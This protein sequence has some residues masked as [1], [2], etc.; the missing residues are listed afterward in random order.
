MRA[1][2]VVGLLDRSTRPAHV[3]FRLN[4]IL[5]ATPGRRL[6]ER[7][8]AFFPVRLEAGG[9]VVTEYALSLSTGGIGVTSEEPVD[10]NTDVRLCFSLEDGG[11]PLA[12][13]GR[14]VY[15]R[16]APDGAPLNEIGIVF[17]GLDQEQKSRIESEVDRLLDH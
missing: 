13:S 9:R 14:A 17:V 11:E 7:A 8:P 10:L 16:S 12:V 3:M 1:L 6:Y 5:H 2:G 15:S 4:R